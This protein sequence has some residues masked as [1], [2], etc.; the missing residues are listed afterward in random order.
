MKERYSKLRKNYLYSYR[1]TKSKGYKSLKNAKRKKKPFIVKKNKGKFFI[2]FL[3]AKNI[4]RYRKRLIK[5]I[6]YL[7]RQGLKTVKYE[8]KHRLI[9]KHHILQH[10]WRRRR[11]LKKQKRFINKL[12]LVLKKKQNIQIK[13]NLKKR[14]HLRFWHK[15]K[16]YYTLFFSKLFAKNILK[17][18]LFSRK[19][20][21]K[22]KLTLDIKE[23]R[24]NKLF[25]KE[26]KRKFIINRKQS[27]KINRKLLKLNKMYK[28]IVAFAQKQH[29]IRAHILLTNTLRKL[30]PGFNLQ[31]TL[32]A[33]RLYTLPVPISE[34]HDNFKA[35]KWLVDAATN[36]LSNENMDVLI[37][38]MLV[39]TALQKGKAYGYLKDFIRLAMEQ[40]HYKR[41]LRRRRKRRY[42]KI[43]WI[44]KRILDRKFRK[45]KSRRW[46]RN[47]R[48]R[49]RREYRLRY[50]YKNQWRKVNG[51]WVRR[52]F[53]FRGK[54]PYYNRRPM[55]IPIDSNKLKK[56]KNNKYQKSYKNKRKIKNEQ[57]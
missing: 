49:N 35:A 30:K 43:R 25:N 31:R 27:K 32:I 47:R 36:K 3:H 20:A 29:I 26:K 23:K 6:K 55:L 53:K 10:K 17:I 51:K 38:E 2:S 42:S 48:E 33:G 12:K 37:A 18:G 5:R 44:F 15:A 41:F 34:N 8:R 11:L 14:K 28:T 50:F 52:K 16:K 54:R 19:V 56:N 45:F 46:R 1:K 13:R 7:N 24:I 9:D 4:K 39:K 40:R 57:R 21:I 22:K